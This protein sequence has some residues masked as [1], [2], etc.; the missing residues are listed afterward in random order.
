MKKLKKGDRVR[1]EYLGDG[2]FLQMIQFMAFVKF[3]KTPHKRFN[4]GEN[5]LVVFIDKL[6]KIKS[7]PNSNLT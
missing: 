1:H 6:T 5:P 3:D 2:T 7:P 4:M